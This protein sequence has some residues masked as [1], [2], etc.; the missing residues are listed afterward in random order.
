[1]IEF[2]ILI[3]IELLIPPVVLIFLPLWSGNQPS[4]KNLNLAM[5]I[6]AKEL[7]HLLNGTIEGN[8]DV[9]VS[10][11]SKIEEATEDSVCF[12]ANPKYEHYV[13]TTPAAIILVSHDF[14]PTQPVQATLIRVADVYKSISFLLENFSQ[15]NDKKG[16]ISP[17]AS[18]HPSAKIG[19]NVSIGAFAVVEEGAEIG[20]NSF[21]APQVFIGKN[22]KISKNVTLYSGVK[23]YH[24]CVIGN[25]CILHANVVIG[26]DGFGF[27]P[28]HDGTFKKV[29][30]IGN[31][32]L[33]DDIEIGANSTVDRATMGSTIIRQGVKLDNLIMVAHNVEIGKN[34]VIA[35]QSGIAGSTKIGENCVVGG[36]VGFVGHIEI[37]DK[38]KVQ[39]GTGVSRSVKKEGSA[40]Y[41]YPALPYFD[42]LRSYSIF[43]KL[44]Q[45][46]KD[47]ESLKKQKNS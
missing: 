11:P 37:A 7:S 28:N 21:I 41:G 34:T 31:V 39:A 45:L 29:A 36:Q 20:D 25:N 1:M 4:A 46:A 10:R 42:Y 19:D 44:P 24:E 13:Y 8:P 3:L 12:F 17:Q 5:Q 15:K 47:V 9:V 43:K 18:V 35:A 26:A 38:V 27:A 6:S 2:L 23:I 16:E 33:E 30:Q 14:Q 40:I 32:I 22:A